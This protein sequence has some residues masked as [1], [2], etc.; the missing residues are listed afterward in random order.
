MTIAPVSSSA[1]YKTTILPSFTSRSRVE[2]VQRF[3]VDASS[4]HRVEENGVLVRL[5]HRRRVLWAHER[6]KRPSGQSRGGVSSGHQ[7]NCACDGSESGFNTHILSGMATD[8]CAKSAFLTGG[9]PSLRPNRVAPDATV[10]GILKS[11]RMVGGRRSET[12]LL[13]APAKNATAMRNV[14]EKRF[15]ILLSRRRAAYG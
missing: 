2:G 10:S 3:P 15:F 12:T 5:N 13:R 8:A 1:R 4:A 7:K 9:Q 6:A 14:I 11:Q